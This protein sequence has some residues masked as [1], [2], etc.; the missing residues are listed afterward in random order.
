MMKVDMTSLV[1]R[2]HRE[3]RL[4]VQSLVVFSEPSTFTGL[5]HSVATAQTPDREEGYSLIFVDRILKL[6]EN[7]VE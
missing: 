1:S 5:Y 7:Y 3:I 2:R 4:R 6:G